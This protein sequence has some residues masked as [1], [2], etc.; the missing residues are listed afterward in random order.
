MEINFEELDYICRSVVVPDEDA[1]LNKWIYEACA[2]VDA[3]F[4]KDFTDDVQDFSTK[5]DVIDYIYKNLGDISNSVW[6]SFH[7]MKPN[8]E[9]DYGDPEFSTLS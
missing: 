2:N 8:S 6:A 1:P 5:E 3:L 9:P 7:N 4:G